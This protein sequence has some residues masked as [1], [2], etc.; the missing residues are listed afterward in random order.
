M[1]LIKKNLVQA[2]EYVQEM[3]EME[4]ILES[5]RNKIINSM[6]VP[7]IMLGEEFVN[8][9]T[10]FQSKPTMIKIDVTKFP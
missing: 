4:A 2:Q 5:Y 3:Y 6:A 1:N 8:S 10:V 9:P 7:S